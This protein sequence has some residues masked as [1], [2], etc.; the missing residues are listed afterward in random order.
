MLY[1]ICLEWYDKWLFW[2]VNLIY[3]FDEIFRIPFW[4]VLLWFFF[5][6][7]SCTYINFLKI[8]LLLVCPLGYVGLKCE[9]PCTYP[10]YGL[11]CQSVC[12]CSRDL[13]LIATGCIQPTTAIGL[14]IVVYPQFV[15][16]KKKLDCVRKMYH[17]RCLYTR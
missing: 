1:R 5:Y 9:I 13:C 12:D 11:E 10:L 7:Q 15:I 8:I 16:K 17:C 4:Y 2:W 6:F 14:L 3:F